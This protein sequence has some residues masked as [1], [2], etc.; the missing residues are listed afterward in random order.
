MVKEERA[1][2]LRVSSLV[3]GN[4]QYKELKIRGLVVNLHISVE[5][6]STLSQKLYVQQ[7]RKELENTGSSG[8]IV[9]KPD[10]TRISGI[11]TIPMTPGIRVSPIGHK[12]PQYRTRK[13]ILFFS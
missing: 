1:V 2:L 8:L 6:F 7:L 5:Y 3:K 10:G 9:S 4:H 11:H 13:I 12:S